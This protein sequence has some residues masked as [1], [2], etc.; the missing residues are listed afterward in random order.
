[1]RRHKAEGRE[2]LP[3]PKYKSKVVSKFMNM[4][5]ERGKKS[6]AEKIVYGAFEQAA[7]KVGKEP[8]ETFQKALDNVRPLVELK[9]RRVGGATYQVPIEVRQDRGVSLA[10]RWI[11]DFARSRK[12][13][14]MVDK[15]AAEII[16]A[17]NS[18]GSAV[19]KRED[20]HKMAEA[21]KAFSHFRW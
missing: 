12:G 16:D 4:M 17:Y 10:M 9:S 13:K 14:P 19:K 3:D 15:L 11:R 6:I 7:K 1:M 2:I 20:I 21:N 18:T 8:L 5:M